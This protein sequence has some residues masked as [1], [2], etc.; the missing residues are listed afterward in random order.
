MKECAIFLHISPN[1]LHIA[2]GKCL[3]KVG[4]LRLPLLMPYHCIAPGEKD[5]MDFPLI[6]NPSNAPQGNWYCSYELQ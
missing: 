4:T 3:G 1:T 5:I 2:L 6:Y